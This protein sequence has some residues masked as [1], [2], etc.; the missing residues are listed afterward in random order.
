[1]W[2]LAVG[3]I[4]WGDMDFDI[5][6]PDTHNSAIGCARDLCFDIIHCPHSE[7]DRGEERDDHGGEEHESLT[8]SRW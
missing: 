3:E 6:E 8:I 4:L 5:F 7:T 1:V 2:A